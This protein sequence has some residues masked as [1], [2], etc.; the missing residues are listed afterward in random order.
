MEFDYTRT[1]GRTKLL[2]DLVGQ[3]GV[4]RVEKVSIDSF[5]QEDHL[6]VACR[7]ESGDWVYPEIAE[8][9]LMLPACLLSPA[10]IEEAVA[11]CLSDRVEEMNQEI[12]SSSSDRNNRFFDEEMEKLDSW[13][14]DM[15]LALEREIS[16]LDQEIK[17]RK[18]EAKKIS[19]LEEKVKAQR[20]IKD[21]ERKR[22]E[23]RRNLYIA[24]DEID[25]KKEALLNKIEK[26]LKQKVERTYLFMIKWKL[27]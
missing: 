2:E 1:E 21:L 7:T 18:S 13:V 22:V 11:V 23:K 27:R 8:K 25:E 20:A 15:K 4:M 5:E 9:M 16:D 10:H 3:S 12:L 17:L 19:R 26:M 6:V 24:Q 14:D